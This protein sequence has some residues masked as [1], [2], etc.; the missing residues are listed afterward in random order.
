VADHVEDVFEGDR[1]EVEA[2]ASVEIGRDRLG[3]IVDD[4]RPIAEIA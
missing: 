2:I 4:N 1:L 3:V